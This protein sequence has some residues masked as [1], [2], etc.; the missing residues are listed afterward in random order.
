MV[1]AKAARADPD[2][3]LDV[4]EMI[5]DCLIYQATAAIFRER[6][7]WQEAGAPA[8]VDTQPADILLQAV[9]A[10]LVI[11]R[12]N[13]AA[14][15]MPAALS[16]R[17]RL[18]RFTTLFTRRLF[19]SPSSPALE[20]VQVHR[21]RQ[22]ESALAWLRHSAPGRKEEGWWKEVM[23]PALEHAPLSPSVLHQYRRRTLE[24]YK[25]R[26]RGD[27]DDDD[28]GGGDDDYYGLPVSMS[29]LDL[30]APFM[31][32]SAAVADVV[33]EFAISPL[34]M[35][36]AADFMLQAALEQYRAYG[37]HGP[38][39]LVQS[40]A[41]GY[42]EDMGAGGRDHNDEDELG[43]NRM[44]HS[45]GHS[46]IQTWHQLKTDRRAR[47]MRV[48]VT[49]ES[50]TGTHHPIHPSA[51]AATTTAHHNLHSLPALDDRVLDLLRECLDIRPRPILIE[52]QEGTL[53]HLSR[54]ETT[55]LKKR[56]GME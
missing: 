21:R 36:M 18:L 47:F 42:D 16:F 48:P 15:T 35:A 5:L 11:F 8:A 23:P 49:T 26:C 22:E 54:E 25:L 40:F 50:V 38:A 3:L 24:V 7:T 55:A 30:L 37:E 1:K 19:H 2:T 33:D 32:L 6:Q 29:L 53:R 10:F 17:V 9:D 43:I 31:A 51:A 34:W 41:W 39:A 27:D 44:F 13:H 14:H 12:R 52:L 45:A 46:A 28:D 4:D 20:D 56:V